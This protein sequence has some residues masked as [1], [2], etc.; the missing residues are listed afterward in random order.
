MTMETDI[1]SVGNKL[2]DIKLVTTLLFICTC[3]VS[4]VVSKSTEMIWH[5]GDRTSKTQNFGTDIRIVVL[6]TSLSASDHEPTWLLQDATFKKMGVIMAEN[7][8]RLLA[9]YDELSAFL[10]KIK[11]YGNSSFRFS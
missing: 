2:C 9:I 1:E 11:L 7:N 5:C 8:G 3:V 4:A 10:T 6:R